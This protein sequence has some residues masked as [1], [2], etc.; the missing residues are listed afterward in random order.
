M[1]FTTALRAF[2]RDGRSGAA[3]AVVAGVVVV[4]VVVVPLVAVGVLDMVD[5][6]GLLAEDNAVPSKSVINSQGRKKESSDA[7]PPAAAPALSHGLGGETDAMTTA[8]TQ[9]PRI[10]L[11][12]P[13]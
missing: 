12:L 2:G 4:G 5:V 3:V 11:R 8:S 9:Q 10:E 6:A 7:L 13:D 1:R